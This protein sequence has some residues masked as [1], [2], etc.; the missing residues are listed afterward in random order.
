MRRPSLAATVLVLL[1][2]L[3]LPA[4][5]SA[6]TTGTGGGATSSAQPG[7]AGAS[8]KGGVALKSIGRFDQP[9]YVTGA[10]GFPQLLFVVEQP[11]KI[12]VLK[13]GK[14]LGRPFLNITGPVNDGGEQ[15]LLSVAFPPNYAQS[16]RFYVFYTAASGAITVDEFRLGSATRAL[17]GSRRNVISIPHA[18]NEN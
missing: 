8:A 16:K 11:G 15:G 5:G 10:P 4:C 12:I 17:P 13:N 3:A 2:S 14:R 6:D 7:D 1:L 9:V 18:E